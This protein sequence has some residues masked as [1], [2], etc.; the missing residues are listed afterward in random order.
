VVLRCSLAALRPHAPVILKVASVGDLRHIGQAR[1]ASSWPIPPKKALLRRRD[2][3]LSPPACRDCDQDGTSASRTVCVVL[4]VLAAKARRSRPPPPSIDRFV[5]LDSARWNSCDRAGSRSEQD[6]SAQLIRL[7][8]A[9]L[10]GRMK[11]EVILAEVTQQD[12]EYA[13]RSIPAFAYDVALDDLVRIVDPDTGRFETISRSGQV[14]IRV[15]IEGTLDRP[16]VR[17]LIDV[18]SSEHGRY[19][20]GKDSKDASLLLLS[21]HINLGL[22]KIRSMMKIVAGPGVEWEFGNIYDENGNFVNW[23]VH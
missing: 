23:W 14:S 4:R 9:A 15:F 6:M 8:I 12:S 2:Q 1:D 10:A 20:V 16:D 19:E 21:L 11:R 5:D 22:D 17:A 7:P 18:A 3:Q 13:I